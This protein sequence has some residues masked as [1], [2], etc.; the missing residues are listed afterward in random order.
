MT[1]GT[2]ILLIL[3]GDPIAALTSN[4]FN[5]ENEIKDVTTKDANGWREC[6]PLKKSFN[7]SA[8]GFIKGVGVNLLKSSENL[9]NADNWDYGTNTITL[10]YAD[11]AFGKKTANLIAFTS[12][13]IHQDIYNVALDDYITFSIYAKG[14]GTIVIKAGNDNHN[15]L[16]TITLTSTLTRYSVTFQVQD[17]INAYVELYK[18]TATSATVANLMVNIGQTAL[19]YQRSGLSFDDLYTLISNGQEL[20][21]KISDQISGDKSYSGSGYLKSLKQTDPV[22][23]IATFT[24]MVE[25]TAELTKSTI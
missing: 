23:D 24:C 12:Y 20:T 15:Q 3:N 6:L 25:G 8:N 18:G 21:M 5:C 13:H 19:D 14:T 10:N 2:D 17:D 4:D 1:N 7:G 22:E 9:L 11:D 16:Y